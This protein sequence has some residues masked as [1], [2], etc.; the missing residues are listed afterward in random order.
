MDN[1]LDITGLTKRFKGFTLDKI[2]LQI[3]PGTIMGFIGPNGAGKTTTIKLIMNMLHADEGHIRVFG[4]DYRQSEKKI[5]NKIAYV[6]E[7]PAFYGDKTIDRMARYYASFFSDWDINT[8]QNCLTR[9]ALSRTK[10]V[11]ELSK[12]QKIKFSL[13]LALS[14]HSDLA[15]L[16]EPTAGLD[17]I[18][19][20]DILNILSSL[21]DDE[22]KSVLISSH[23]TDDILRIADSIT[24]INE[25]RIVQ[26]GPK[27]D[28]LAD[29]K[30]IHYRKNTLSGNITSSLLCRE[31]L[32]FGST[33]VTNRF[34]ALRPELEDGLAA[35]D[36]KIENT[37]LD[38]ILIA[39]VKG[40]PSC[41]T[42]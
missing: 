30:K 33:G 25:G 36:I 13:A 34:R 15:I 8:F 41:G 16:D 40:D 32:A 35:G 20:R 39:L 27:D 19:R 18:I 7:E 14:H 38:D 5:K 17:P 4:L 2:D 26:T 10:K 12:G 22:N 3:P 28:L 23:I 9:F 11:R 31:D 6:G 42:S 1:M 37:N 21:T 24:F 29:W